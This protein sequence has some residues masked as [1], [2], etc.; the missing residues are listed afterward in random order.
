MR[1]P[2]C[3]TLNQRGAVITVELLQE[4][5]SRIP[6]AYG[7]ATLNQIV[8]RTLA[9]EK[10]EK[11]VI[12]IVETPTALKTAVEA[13]SEHIEIRA[14]LDLSELALT[15][16]DRIFGRVPASVKSI[17]VRTTAGFFLLLCFGFF[18]LKKELV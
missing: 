2:F 11:K 8:R 13:G 3:F 7:T 18:L 4:I 14:H 16:N 5:R 9:Q 6:N 17:R 12:T 10:L 15:E 1:K